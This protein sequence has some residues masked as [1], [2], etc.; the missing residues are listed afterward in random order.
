MVAQKLLKLLVYLTGLRNISLKLT[1]SIFLS[2]IWKFCHILKLPL[3]HF[4]IVDVQIVKEFI[5]EIVFV[6]TAIH[7]EQRV[8]GL[9]P[10]LLTNLIIR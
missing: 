7:R 5:V 4:I 1:F 9:L 2:Y 6:I 8:I 3:I 10:F